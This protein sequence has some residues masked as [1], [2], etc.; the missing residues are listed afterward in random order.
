[1]H[2]Y[3]YIHVVIEEE[4]ERETTPKLHKSTDAKT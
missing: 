3:T 1:M 4:L 2:T